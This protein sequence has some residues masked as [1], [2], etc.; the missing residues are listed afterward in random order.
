MIRELELLDVGDE[1]MQLLC[2]LSGEKKDFKWDDIT[3]FWLKYENNDDHQTFIFEHENRIV[4][5]A[6]VLIENKLLH[7]GSKVGHI[8]DV[9]VDKRLRMSGVGKNLIQK[10]VEFCR[11]ESCYK[12]ILDCSQENVP[13][14]ESCGFTHYENCMRINF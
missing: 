10:C 6:T 1:Y 14:Y 13:F 9:V 12:A 2:Q 8:E 3:G 5:T 7:Y 11:R 4:G